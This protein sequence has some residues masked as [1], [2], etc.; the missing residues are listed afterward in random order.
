MENDWIQNQLK[1]FRAALDSLEQRVA[2]LEQSGPPVEDHPPAAEASAARAPG[3]K[4]Y[5]FLFTRLAVVCFALLGALVLRV[6]TQQGAVDAWLGTVIGLVYCAALLGAPYI[7][8]LLQ[9]PVRQKTVLQ[10]C[11]VVLAPMIVLEMFHKGSVLAAVTATGILFAVGLLGSLAGVVG[12]RR[13]L[14]AVGL[15]VPLAGITGLGLTTDAAAF[16]A[17]ALTGLAALA[18]G[19]A[20]YKRWP[21]LRP[22][23]LIP[24]GAVLAM[25]VLLTARRSGLPPGTSTALLICVLAVWVLVAANHLLRIKTLGAGEAAWL[26]LGTC[27]ALLLG[28]FAWRAPAAWFGPGLSVFSLGV[29]FVGHRMKNTFLHVFSQLLVVAATIAAFLS[30]GLLGTPAG[31]SAADVLAGAATA[32]FAF[33]HAWALGGRGLRGRGTALLGWLAPVSLAGAVALAYATLRLTAFHLVGGDQAFRVSETI[34]LAVFAVLGLALGRR[35][36]I[37]SL[38]GFGLVGTGLLAVKVVFFDLF[39]MEGGSLLGSVVALGLAFVVASLALRRNI[40]NG[41]GR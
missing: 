14:T 22:L 17:A 7:P 1:Q 12:N 5:S 27:W 13:G 31:G 15:L 4:A 21:V 41:E 6:A 19:L 26:P 3:E 16:R 37:R 38:L 11:G 34:L 35:L 8:G 33:L 36:E 30:G 25:G 28:A 2:R 10:Y 23:V 40:N 20:H 29:F 39:S 24:A 18:L 9:L 32:I